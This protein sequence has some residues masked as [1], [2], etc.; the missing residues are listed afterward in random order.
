MGNSCVGGNR[1]TPRRPSTDFQLQWAHPYH[2][3]G[4]S[5]LSCFSTTARPSLSLYSVAVTEIHAVELTTVIEEYMVISAV[6]GASI[7]DKSFERVVPMLHGRESPVEVTCPSILRTH[8]RLGAL[9][10]TL[11]TTRRNHHRSCL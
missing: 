7:Q 10:H 11:R 5:N 4:T 6:D 1:L 3:V 9:T 2:I 8:C